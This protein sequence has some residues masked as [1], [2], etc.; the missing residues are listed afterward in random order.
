MRVRLLQRGC[1]AHCGSNRSSPSQ[2]RPNSS[3]SCLAATGF[4]PGPIW[5]GSCVVDSTCATPRAIGD[6]PPHAKALRELEAQGV[7]T[8][9][10]ASVPASPRQWNP[11]RLN[12]RLEAPTGVPKWVE[13]VQ[14][15]RLV[16]VT[17]EEDLRIWNEL[18][19]REHPLHQG[20]LVG[21]P[22]RYLVAS[23]HGWLGGI[24]F[25][26]AALRSGGSR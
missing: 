16:E 6:W 7:W 9:P 26:S 22:L 11:T 12:H 10:A 1:N 21:R 20:R 8:L 18:M 5:P 2:I 17:T 4:S 19:N 3:L 23:D 13:D 15:L 14:G 25:G 24:G